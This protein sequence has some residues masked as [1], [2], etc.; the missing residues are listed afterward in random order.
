[1]REIK[2][3]GLSLNGN[4][5]YGNLSVLKMDGRDNKAGSY[6]SNKA[7]MPFAYPVRPETVGQY[8][9]VRDEYDKEIYEGDILIVNL[10][11]DEEVKKMCKVVFDCGSFEFFD[12]INWYSMGVPYK[13]EVVGNIHEHDLI[14]TI[15]LLDSLP[16]EP[17]NEEY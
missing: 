8:T 1:M 5:H 15:Q 9:G 3:R 17:K 14:S 13:F 10:Y 6:I 11:R 12:N 4:W 16:K 2:F 7:G